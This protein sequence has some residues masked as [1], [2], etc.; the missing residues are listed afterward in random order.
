MLSSIKVPKTWYIATDGFVDF[1]HQN[2]LEDLNEQK[3]K[4]L[5]EIRMDY[6]HII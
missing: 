6:P 1:L 3:Y 5:Y 4:T 2:N